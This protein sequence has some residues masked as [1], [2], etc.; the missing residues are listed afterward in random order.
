M[1]SLRPGSRHSREAFQQEDSDERYEL[2][3]LNW[4][5]RYAKGT[6]WGGRFMPRRGGFAPR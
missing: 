5:R 6:I 3:E 4:N 1:R 2:M